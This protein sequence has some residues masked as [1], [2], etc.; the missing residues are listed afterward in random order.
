MQFS[1]H[2]IVIP[3][4]PNRGEYLLYNTRTQ[5][6]IKINQELKDL[7]DNFSQPDYFFLRS[8][9]AYEIIQ[10]HKSGILS[11]SREEDFA[12]LKSHMEQIKH[13]VDTKLFF[14]TILTTHACNFKCVYCFEESSRVNKK[15]TME[16]A[17]ANH[18]MD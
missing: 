15:M 9:Y 1:F 2:T 12:R 4:Y 6:M 11:V 3:D 18:G 7:I 5:A 16:T 13:G 8:Q 17:A 10:L 14:V